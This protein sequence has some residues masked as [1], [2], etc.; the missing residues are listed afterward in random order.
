[1]E[2][3][4]GQCGFSFPKLNGENWRSWKFNIEMLLK[5]QGLYGFLDGSEVM[6]E[7][8]KVSERDK[9]EFD[10][11][12]Q[13][14]SSIVAM[15]IEVEQ[16]NLIMG[17]VDI[18]E[19]W[20][21]LK[22]TFE[23]TSRARIAALRTEFINIR[24]QP[25]E[26]MAIYLGRLKQAKDRLVEAGKRVEND[27]YGYQML[28]HLPSKFSNIV[29]Q[30]YQLD[31]SK[32]TP[33]NIKKALLAEDDRLKCEGELNE[34]GNRFSQSV[35]V[36]KKSS[37]SEQRYKNNKKKQIKCFKCGKVGHFSSQCYEGKPH[38]KSFSVNFN[39]VRE[40]HAKKS[41]QVEWIIDSGASHHFISSKHLIEN[42]KACDM[43]VGCVGDN[44]VKV[45]GYGDVKLD[46]TFQGK[47]D[48]Y[49]KECLLG[50]KLKTQF[51]FWKSDR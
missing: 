22:D 38:M 1:M 11:R 16:Q 32:F 26:S 47:K 33:E 39:E 34:V 42:F 21:I 51:N 8:E 14:A 27:E 49:F 46:F 43:T 15:C 30:L 29:Q 9:L 13:K 10:R 7:G 18:Q 45:Q 12:K 50:F 44:E 31:D 5:Y 2:Q 36:A 48:C 6:P 4:I 35:L 23:P 20:K 19:M 41:N 37:V 17:T 28:M 25:S 3:T 40:C 24:Y